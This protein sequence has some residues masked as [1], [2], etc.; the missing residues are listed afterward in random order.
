VSL[1]QLTPK[2]LVEIL[3]VWAL[4]RGVEIDTGRPLK[5][6]FEAM[7]LPEA[8]A[9][10]HH[11]ERDQ[12]SPTRG[13]LEV[14]LCRQRTERRRRGCYKFEIKAWAYQDER[15]RGHIFEYFSIAGPDSQASGS[16]HW[17]VDRQRSSRTP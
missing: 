6:R 9:A 17:F 1:D 4:E 11:R 12:Y 14:E 2:I 5:R 8:N 3:V 15:Q 10:K 7:N 13:W 16:W